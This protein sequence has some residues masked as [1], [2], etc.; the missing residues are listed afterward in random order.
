[1]TKSLLKQLEKH[2][3]AGNDVWNFKALNEADVPAPKPQSGSSSPPPPS[4]NQQE[5][6]QN[7][8]QESPQ[9]S[10][11]DSPQPQGDTKTQLKTLRQTITDSS[12]KVG[13]FQP[14]FVKICLSHIVSAINTATGSKL[15]EVENSKALS[16]QCSDANLDKNKVKEAINNAIKELE[17]IIKEINSD[18]RHT[19]NADPSP[20]PTETPSVTNAGEGDNPIGDDGSGG[21][22]VGNMRR[23]DGA[24][25]TG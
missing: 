16:D 20:K 10:S 2:L 7:S 15:G 13:S 1:M 22:N 19:Q 23:D 9:N 24:E 8:P 14:Q 4:S 11:Q 17:S 12:E 18:A 3:D 21:S 5:S 25:V 6:S